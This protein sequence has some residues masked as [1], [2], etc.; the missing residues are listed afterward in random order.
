MEWKTLSLCCLLPSPAA[1]AHQ[2]LTSVLSPLTGR[3]S[4]TWS[5]LAETCVS[6]QN[7]FTVVLAWSAAAGVELQQVIVQSPFQVLPFGFH[8]A[9]VASAENFVDGLQLHRMEMNSVETISAGRQL[10]CYHTAVRELW[11]CCINSGLR[12]NSF[13]FLDSSM[14]IM[15][16]CYHDWWAPVR[17]HRSKTLLILEVCVGLAFLDMEF[18]SGFKSYIKTPQ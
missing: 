3:A 16:M 15:Q 1:G 13:V 8:V 5:T 10:R 9:K 4:I 6:H 14:Y 12:K 11:H 2:G 18:Q 7:G 17:N